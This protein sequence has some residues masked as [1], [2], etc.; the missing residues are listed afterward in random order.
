MYSQAQSRDQRKNTCGRSQCPVQAD[1]DPLA[2]VRA[3]VLYGDPSAHPLSI[4]SSNK[5][6]QKKDAT[7]VLISSLGSHELV[8]QRNRE[9]SQQVQRHQW[10]VF[11]GS[12]GSRL[13]Y[14]VHDHQTLILFFL[15]N[16][17]LILLDNKMPSFNM[18]FGLPCSSR[19][20]HHTALA[21][22]M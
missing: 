5:A 9:K 4:P 8:G 20:P 22:E 7:T 17:T 2:S 11:P 15:S 19:W 1:P 16:S 3:R 21:N 6:T 18:S 12:K 14:I 10:T 13:E